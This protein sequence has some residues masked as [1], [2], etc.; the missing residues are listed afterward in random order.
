M[1]AEVARMRELIRSMTSGRPTTATAD[2]STRL[3]TV[4]VAFFLVSTTMNIVIT[5]ADDCHGG[6]DRVSSS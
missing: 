3:L 5:L 2:T 4:N 1:Q 6:I